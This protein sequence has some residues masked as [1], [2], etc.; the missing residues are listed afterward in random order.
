MGGVFASFQ[1]LPNQKQ[2]PTDLIASTM[3][4]T[5]PVGPSVH[6]AMSQDVDGLPCLISKEDVSPISNCDPNPKGDAPVPFSFLVPKT[7][8]ASDHL[9]LRCRT[10]M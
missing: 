1:G 8:N 4:L 7:T 10:A 3:A 2:D 5:W 6:V 9:A